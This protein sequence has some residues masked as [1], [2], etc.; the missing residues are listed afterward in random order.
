MRQ[1]AQHHIGPARI[2]QR[3][4]LARQPFQ[5][6]V[7][8]HV[9]HGVDAKH[10]AQPEVERQIAVRRRQLGIVIA[11][12]VVD[13]VGPRR[14]DADE[15]MTA[16]HAGDHEAA[17]A[18]H[19][20]GL[21]R[22]P[23]RRDGVAVGLRQLRQ[24]RLVVAHGEALECRAPCMLIDIV[25]DAARQAAHQRVAVGRQ[26]SE[27]IAGIAQHRQDAH[28]GGRRIEPHAIADAPFAGRIVR[29]DQREPLVGGRHGAQAAPAARQFRHEPHAP[30][31]GLI[32]HHIHFRMRA[33]PCQSLEA[34]G[35]RD[36]AAVDFRHGDVH[37]HV[38]RAQAL[39]IGEP[40]VAIAAAE[41]HLQDG[42]I[43]GQRRVGLPRA[44][45]R[46]G[47]KRRGIEHQRHAMRVAQLLQNLA[48][49]RLLERTERQRQRTEPG[50]EQ[51]VGQRV[52]HLG[53]A[54]L[55]VRAI[56]QQ[57]HHRRVA[58]APRGPFALPVLYGG[59]ATVAM[60]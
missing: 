12:V 37:R 30:G 55:Q 24:P 6:A 15:D 57:R 29:Q 16:A 35:S 41:N 14:L 58:Q 42:R 9:H 22:A 32:A 10:M 7:L 2:G 33:T 52:E 39:A 17:V 3:D 45:E 48:A 25:G 34:D 8:A 53:V 40:V 4:A 49:D 44:I 28:H 5:V 60:I 11:G 19:R 26:R 50:I 21:R 38:P 23:A 47:G 59:H 27:R 43:V 18:H 31:I 54:R 46:R 36:D 51:S 56:E 13:P 1:R 20:I